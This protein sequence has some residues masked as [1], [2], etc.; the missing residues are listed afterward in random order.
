MGWYAGYQIH[1]SPR[2]TVKGGWLEILISN[3]SLVAQSGEVVGRRAAEHTL[4]LPPEGRV[5]AESALGE[6]GGYAALQ[7]HMLTGGDEPLFFA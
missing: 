3:S 2:R 7:Q 1:L 6:A 5:V 4:V